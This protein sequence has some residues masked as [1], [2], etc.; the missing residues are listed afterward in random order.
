MELTELQKRLERLDENK[1]MDMVKN[2]RQ[3]GYSEDIRSYAVGLLE[4]RG[5]TITDLQLTGNYENKTYDYASDIL[6]AFNKNSKLAILLYGIILV[7]KI[8]DTWF[9]PTTHAGGTYLLLGFIICPLLYLLFLVKSFSNQSEFYK[10]TGDPYG[11][12]GAVMYLLLGMPF[13]IIMYFIF[14]N[15]MKERM[16]LIQ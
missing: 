13:Y 1:L 14:Q 9:T 6:S 16:K 10:L 4:Q 2:Y 12:E 5:V 3:Y 11:A 7:L 15:Q 8:I